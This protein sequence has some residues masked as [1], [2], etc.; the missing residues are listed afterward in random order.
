MASDADLSV[1]VLTFNEAENLPACL[2][3]VEPLEAEV[4]VVDSGSE[5]RTVEIAEEH[6]AVVVEHPF[7]HYAAQRNWAQRNLPLKTEWILHLDADERLTEELAREINRTLK[8]PPED[9]NGFMLRQRTVFRGQWIR[10]GGHYPSHHMRLY[11]RSAGRCEDRLYDQHFLVEGPTERLDHDYIDVVASDLD[12]WIRRHARWAKMEA[13]ELARTSDDENQVKGDPTGTPIERRRWMR[14]DLYGSFPLYVRAFLYWL[15]RYVFRLGFLDGKQGFLFH[16][17]HGF[18][19]RV[20]VDVH[21]DERL[22]DQ[23]DSQGES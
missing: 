11:R 9:V 8:D 17:L 4:F 14:D 2:R 3:S 15:Y 13:E 20:L 6:G 5:D 10:H 23:E 7:E 16:F 22:A 19:Y 1:V 21:L 12:S 18:W